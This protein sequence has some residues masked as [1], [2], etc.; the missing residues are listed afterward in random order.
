MASFLNSIVKRFRL[1]QEAENF[2][3]LTETITLGVPFR[4]T[5][6]WVLIFAIFIASLGLNVNSTAVII[7][8]MLISPLM[9]P[10]MG[11]G[12]GLGI[13]D[14]GL[15]RLSLNNFAYAVGVSL[16][17]STLYFFVTPINSAHSEL[18]ARTNPTTYDVLIAFF[19]GLAGIVATSSKLKGNVIPGVAIATALMPPLCTAGYGLATLQWNFF[20][21]ALYLFIINSVFI[22]AATLLTVRLLKLPYKH[23]PNVRDE[24]RVRRIITFFLVATT[25]PSIYFAYNIVRQERFTRNADRFVERVRILPN[26]YLLNKTIDPKKRE[27]ILVYGG[28]GMTD[29][30]ITGL[31]QRLPDFDL[32]DASLVVQQGFSFLKESEAGKQEDNRIIQLSATLAEKEKQIQSMQATL[33]SSRM[34]RNLAQQVYAELSTMYPGLDRFIL[35]PSA[36]RIDSSSQTRQMVSILIFSKMPGKKDRGIIEGWLKVRLDDPQLDVLMQPVR[37]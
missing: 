29:T 24:V 37:R 12:L 16:A 26:D 2:H 32:E 7:G 3:K 30:D 20:L 23:L 4:G 34:Y 15:V 31:R 13:N 19:G 18:L 10:I 35:Q 17:T 27:I 14:L 25:A 21:G 22:A 28:A 5:N 33:D 1:K 36:I 11:L 6:L 8:A 9:G